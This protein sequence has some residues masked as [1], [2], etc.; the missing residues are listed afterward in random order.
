MYTKLFPR[1]LK[2]LPFLL[3][4]CIFSASIVSAT[5]T[6]SPPSEQ[7]STASEETASPEETPE[8][9]TTSPEEERPEPDAYFETIQTNATEGWPQG[10][11]IWAE[12]AVVMDL[13]SGAILYGKI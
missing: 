3:L 6:E 11:A 1:L 2:Y 13:D 8:E 9:E 10:P 7:E 4:L 5:E 12:S